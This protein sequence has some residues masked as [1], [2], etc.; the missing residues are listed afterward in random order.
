MLI[1]SMSR[2]SNGTQLIQYVLRYSLKEKFNQIKSDATVV[3]QNH[4][5]ST[6]VE[7]IIKE[8]KINESFRIYH[9][10]DNV[11]LFHDVLSFSPAD[12]GIITEA[13]MK[14]I[15][16]KYIELRA[17]NALSIIIHHGEKNHDHIHCVTAGVMLDGYSSRISKQQFKH[18]KLELEKFQQEKFPEL[19][20]S[21][22]NHRIDRSQPKE[23]IIQA[24]QNVRE[25][26]K[27]K[28]LEILQKTF[29]VANSQQDFLQRLTEQNCLPYYRNDS[30]QGVMI[31]GRKFRFSKLGFDE[32]KFNEL[33]Q[34]QKDFKMLNNL[35][36]LRTQKT[37]HLEMDE[38]V[39][40]DHSSKLNDDDNVLEELQALRNEN[41]LSQSHE[42]V[43]DIDDCELPNV[44]SIE[45]IRK[46]KDFSRAES[47]LEM[48]E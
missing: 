19:S 10:R 12:K 1:K 5:R 40:K 28:L 13:M 2:K 25:T 14:D 9:R 27:N 44:S 32:S 41:E 7:D 45:G 47:D 37:H 6:K 21:K 34:R 26:G 48:E 20:A 30:I 4:I 38:P 43:I 46:Y 17:K 3:L 18:L 11:K 39:A 24:V 8:F 33:D 16:E 15:A 42:R 31:E 36:Q 29:I 22:I 35:D 23:Q